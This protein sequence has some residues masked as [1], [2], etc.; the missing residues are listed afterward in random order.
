MPRGMKKGGMAQKKGLGGDILGGLGGF[1]GGPLGG[2]IGKGVGDVGGHLLGLKKG[3]KRKKMPA[4]TEAMSKK[5]GGDIL[6]SVGQHAGDY[7]QQMVQSALGFKK[8]GRR[9]KC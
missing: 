4:P 3:G 5:L 1:F 8:G 2:L 7:L 6:A 9:R